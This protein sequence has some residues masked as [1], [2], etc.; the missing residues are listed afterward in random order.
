MST[1]E[2]PASP[3]PAADLLR[4]VERGEIR[5]HYL[6]IVALGDLTV[7]GV[8]ALA[9]WH[10]G[11]QVL[12][13]GEFL[14]P[15]LQTGAIADI[16]RHVMTESCSALARWNDLHPQRPLRVSVNASLHQLLEGGAADEVAT[17]LSTSGL[18]PSQL[19]IEVREDALSDAAEV[20]APV[21]ER[22]KALGV[23][24]SVDDFGTGASSL[25]ALL[26]HR[27]DE[28]KIDRSFVARMDSD[29]SAAAIVRGVAVFAA[30]LEVEVVAEG[31]ERPSQE[32]ALRA[33][34]CE[35]AQGWLYA[36]PSPDL[37]AAVDTAERSAAA[38]RGRRAD[39]HAIT[40]GGA[41][42]VAAGDAHRALEARVEALDIA[43]DR[44]RSFA[45]TLSHDLMQPVSA[46]DGFLG[47]L[48]RFAEE[49][50]PDHREWLAAA[51][52]STTRVAETI[53]ALHRAATADEVELTPVSIGSV[54][55]D[56]IGD[57]SGS[58]EPIDVA[59][60]DLPT[61]LADRGLLAQVLANLVQN[62][63]RYRGE[64][65]VCLDVS[66]RRDGS[67]WAITIVDN[68]RGIADEELETVF[69]RGHRGRSSRHTEGTGTGL[70][71]VRSLMQRMSGDVWAER[72]HQGA[73]LVLVLQAADAAD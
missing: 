5:V 59:T 17:V 6:P 38:S 1:I 4:A 29:P 28:L 42:D 31:V 67:M 33:L 30:S 61:V 51:V 64:P 16:G 53:S 62:S 60:S 49:L 63:V 8:E 34:G 52:R 71:T 43:N 22:L 19:C 69:E 18:E 44:L 56:V 15:A 23:R 2:A 57:H 24:V 39:H 26:H 70:A 25:V 46:L 68:G 10:R 45:S 40:W 13:A 14:V 7:V 12:D 21:L 32:H 11:D 20:V 54:L 3:A 37:Q 27:V 65:P 47:L 35:A 66:A 9:R 41:T 72:S 58:T 73:R 50:S 55:A 48:D 36:R